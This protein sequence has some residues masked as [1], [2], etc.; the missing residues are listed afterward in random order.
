MKKHSSLKSEVYAADKADVAA[1]GT[2]E[3]EAVNGGFHHAIS[4]AQAHRD[5]AAAALKWK[6][7]PGDGNC[8]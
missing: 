5:D 4:M 2:A 6:N 7:T 1:V 3:L 8:Q